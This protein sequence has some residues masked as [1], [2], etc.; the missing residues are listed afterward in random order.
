M[1]K[2]RVYELARDLGVD[3]KEV[4]EQAIELGLNVK[5]A[6]SGLDEAEV[7]LVTMALADGG[8]AST[9]ETD[10]ATAEEAV[11]EEAV[12]EE[13]SAEPEPETAEA[14]AAPAEEPQET[15]DED[16]Q[17][18][19]VEAGMTVE[20]FAAAIGQPASE[21]VRALLTRGRPVGAPAV[22][23]E[24]LMEEVA[25]GFGV[26]VDGRQPSAAEEPAAPAVAERPEFD[27]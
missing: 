26:I 18:A 20:E 2:T 19:E 13:A 5:T 15:A 6:S 1:A 27:D 23:P 25:E 7:E 17:I 12:A 10:E 4:L 14:E 9:T 16:V 3:S 24:D 21:V 11:A 22:M 8:G